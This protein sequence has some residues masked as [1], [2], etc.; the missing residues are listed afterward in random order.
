M[1]I[2]RWVE[3]GKCK[4]VAQWHGK[5]EGITAIITGRRR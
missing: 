5:Q 4:G 1:S 2:G 3:K